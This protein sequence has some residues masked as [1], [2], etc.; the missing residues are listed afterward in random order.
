MS[1]QR[2][3][4][5]DPREWLNRAYSSLEHAKATHPRVYL[6]E[7]CFDAQQAA[8]KAVKAVLLQKSIP[9]PHVH[10]LDRLLQLVAETGE[11]VAGAVLHA[12]DLTRYAVAT[13]YPGAL[14]EVTESEYQDAIAL[15]EAV[16]R[17]AEVIILGKD[18]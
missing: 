3:S 17:W 7:L 12:G 11:E 2:H 8:E 13:R 18:K 10:D 6:E 15:A 16:V 5:A 4:H 14:G 9:F 1:V